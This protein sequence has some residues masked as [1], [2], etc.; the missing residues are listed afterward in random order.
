MRASVVTRARVPAYSQVEGI[1]THVNLINVNSINPKHAG[2]LILKVRAVGPS[3]LLS[4]TPAA[5]CNP[6]RPVSTRA[7]RPTKRCA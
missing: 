5:S 4:R 3:H 7:Q 6:A 2:V 1:E